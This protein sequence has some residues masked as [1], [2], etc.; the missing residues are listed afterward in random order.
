MRCTKLKEIIDQYLAL[1]QSTKNLSDKTITA[2]RSDYNDFLRFIQEKR[3]DELTILSYV[4]YLS[5]VRRL[6]S[7]T[8][9]RKLISIKMLMKYLYENRINEQNYYLYH[10]RLKKKLRVHTH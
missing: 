2:Y 1:I 8:I 5:Q 9:N 7:S 4:Q 6:R 3:I 10:F